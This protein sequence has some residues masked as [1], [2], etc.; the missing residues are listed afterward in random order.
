L[1]IQWNGVMTVGNWEVAWINAA[2]TWFVAIVIQK[3]GGKWQHGWRSQEMFRH[4]TFFRHI[5]L[6]H[7]SPSYHFL[8]EK[9]TNFHPYS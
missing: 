1:V 5:Y 3:Y 6:T 2:I 7:R 9:K 4:K 8:S